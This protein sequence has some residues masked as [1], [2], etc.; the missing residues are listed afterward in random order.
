M[1]LYRYIAL[2]VYFDPSVYRNTM[3]GKPWNSLDFAPGKQIFVRRL[4][5]QS[6]FSSFQFCNTPI[7]SRDFLIR[8]WLGLDLVVSDSLA[9]SSFHD[10]LSIISVSLDL[11]SPDEWPPL[12]SSITQAYTVRN[13]WSRFWHRLIYRSFRAHSSL[14]A[15]KIL[16][17][18]RGSILA[19]YVNNALVFL[20][21]GLMHTLVERTHSGSDSKCNC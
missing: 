10:I 12:F 13:F 5:C 1:L 20:L 9:L 16:G 2:C 15:R 3:D 18:R 11:D 6:A 14:F 4:I 17:I 19:R 21:S 7:T 8:F